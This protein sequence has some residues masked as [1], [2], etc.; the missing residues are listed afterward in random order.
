MKI[1][2]LLI[3]VF[4][5]LSLSVF[6]QSGGVKG[7]VVTRNG[8][9]AVSDVKITMTPG[10]KTTITDANGNFV[11]E[12][13]EPGSYSLRFE[14]VEFEPLSLAVRI[15][16]LIRNINTVIIVPEITTTTVADDAIFAEF[17][18][19]SANDAQ[20]LPS[21]LSA[22]KDV[23][24]NIA[25]YK[26]SEMRFNVRGYESQYSDVYLN[27]IQMNDALTG[28][29]PWSLWS[30]LNDATR[31]QETTSGLNVAGVGLGGIAGTTNI[32]ARASQ[33]RK[34]FRASV[35]NGN[36]MYR[37]RAM[38]T[39]ASGVSDK[40]WSFAL[41]ASTRQGGN[42][43]VDGVYYNA[44]GY[45]ASVE[46]IIAQ[47]HRLALTVL[48]APT[49]RGAQQA[50]TQEAY[51]LV[52]NNYYN[53]NW[54]YQDG[55]MRNSRVRDNHEP[56]AMLNYIFDIN[57]RSQL[58]VATSFRFGKN[59]YS[60]LNWK[61]GSDP[62]PDYYRFLPS[63]KLT[64]KG[65][66]AAAAAELA[67]LWMRNVDNIRHL[68]W[69]AMYRTNYKQLP[70]EIYGEGKPS[71]YI[72]EERHTDQ[73]DWNFATQFSH[74]FKNN[75]RIQV[76]VNVRRNRTE[77]YDK[78]KDLLGGDYFI[79]I[80]KF[81]ERDLG[82]N[83]LAYQNNLLYYAMYGHAQAVTEG[84]KFGY[85][86]YAHVFNTKAW[87]MYNFHICGLTALDI[88]LGG[89]IGYVEMWREGLWAKGLFPTTSYGDSEKLDYLTFK[90]K[91]NLSYKF[92]ASNAVEANFVYMHNAPTFQSSF[93]SART[94]NDVTPGLTTEKIL[95]V[96]AS[97]NLRI[98]DAKA[99]L[100]GFFTDIKDQ[101]DVISFYDDGAGTF[102]NF[103]LSGIDKRYFGLEFGMSIPLYKGL[104]LNGAVSY[105]QYT[106]NSNP[107]Y[108]QVRDNSA[109]L[110]SSGTVYWKDMH[111]E[112]TPQLA[113]N[114]GL[115]FR[116]GN[117]WF[118]SA[119]FNYYDNMYLSMNPLYRT[120]DV[121]KAASTDA[122]VAA[123]RAQ[124]KF[125]YAYTLNASIGKN[126]YI[127]R[128]YTLG[129]SLEVKNILNNQNIKTGGYEQMRLN[130][131]YASESSSDVIGYSRFDS[132]YFYMF[133]TT[134]Y[135]NMYFRF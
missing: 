24:N 17:D 89:E 52:G 72:V 57:D 48:G 40:G 27:G 87:T 123:M 58:T 128:K 120:D 95:G 79:D 100:S 106:Y 91:A 110:I 70:N 14:A 90:A 49:E 46:K 16:K 117:N 62:R 10:E 109:E 97:Y 65:D 35:V 104:S 78:I 54:G 113:A 43:Y 20:S 1:K 26:F 114:V 22:S 134:Y 92:S 39:Y 112:S 6:A 125:D 51:D 132:K 44:Y 88:N 33:M 34:G 82:G 60:A 9:T 13:I 76:G 42:S 99:R 85:D 47:R 15:D 2:S 31:N 50:S 135:L 119:D 25:S 32:N 53:P 80:D 8:R 3:L 4:S 124:E 59:G 127:H 66:G 68:N 71:N 75:S 81:A 96:D 5:L 11:F 74:I 107:Y 121:L 130:K 21:S 69:D 93:V 83:E 86:Y 115:S 61:Q 56:I 105:G 38:L 23:F 12:N 94:R 41:S 116:S 129:F 131:L 7:K 77:Y 126:W 73:R 101:S 133:G 37:F 84:D 98:G 55:K 103:A 30:G 29:T 63:Y 111:V 18:T 36:A 28:Y 45:F 102:T 64:M 67:D 108:E 19:E 118:L 122:E